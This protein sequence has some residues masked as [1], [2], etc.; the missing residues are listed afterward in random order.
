[1]D[2]PYLK[3]AMETFRQGPRKVFDMI[4]MASMQRYNKLSFEGDVNK[5]TIHAGQSIGLIRDTP[6]VAEIVRRIV[7]EATETMARLNDILPSKDAV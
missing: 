3:L 4:S 6:D 5:G 2:T 1:M 7:A